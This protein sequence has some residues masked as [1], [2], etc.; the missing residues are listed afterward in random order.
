MNIVTQLC[1]W[2]AL[3]LLSQQ[4]GYKEVQTSL[5]QP[6]KMKMMEICD[7]GLD[8]DGDGRVDIFDPDCQC[9]G[10][11]PPNLVPNGQ[12]NQTNGCCADL[13]QVNCLSDWVVLGPSPDYISDNCPNTNLRPDVR[14]L[15]NALNQGFND[16]YIFSVVQMVD[17]RQFSES[18]G[19]CLTQ[20]MEAGKV[21]EVSFDLANLRNDSP[22]IQFSLVGINRCDRLGVY[23]TR[24]NNSFC[25]IGLPSTTLGTINSQDLVQGWNT[26]TFSVTPDE[27]IGAIFYTVECGFTTNVAQSTLYMVMDNVTIRET[28]GAPVAPNINVLGQACVEELGLVVPF[29][30]NFSYQWYKDSTL[31]AGATDTLLSLE[32][33]LLPY[34][35]VYHVLVSDQEGNCELSNPFTLV[36]PEQSSSINAT[37]CAGESY[38][39]KG[40]DLSAEGNY[41]DTLSSNW[42]CD[43]IVELQLE[44]LEASS[45][46]LSREICAGNPF[47]FGGRMLSTGGSYRDTLLNANG[48]DSIVLLELTVLEEQVTDLAIALC[49]GETYLFGGNILSA[50]GTY[51]DTLANRDGCDSVLVLELEVL[52]VQEVNIS[53]SI[54]AGASFP[55]AGNTLTASGE[56]QNVLSG[57]L[58]CD[59]TVT[60][61]L[62]V[63]PEQHLNLSATICDGGTFPFAGTTL[64]SSGIYR[65]TLLTAAGCDSILELDLEVLEVTNTFIS[66]EI[67]V[68]TTIDF[69]GN[70]ISTSGVYRDTVTSAEGCDSL[71]ILELIVSDEKQSILSAS[72][73]EGEDYLFGDDLLNQTGVY[74][75]TIQTM[76]GCD[77][78]IILDL[79]LLANTLGDTLMVR[80]PVGTSFSFAG[81]TYFSAGLYEAVLVGSNG[82]DSTAFLSLS[83]FDPC[84]VPIQIEGLAEGVSCNLA[85]NGQLEIIAL[86]DFPP[87]QYAINQADFQAN[88]IFENLVSGEYLIS[89]QDRFGCIQTASFNVPEKDEKL[90]VE[91]GKDTSIFLGESIQLEVL[92]M[93][94]QPSQSQWF[95]EE[96]LLCDDCIAWKVNPVVNSIYTFQAFD[97]FGCLARDE[98]R[99]EVISPPEFYIPNA[100]SPNNDGINDVFK[101]ESTADGLVSIKE[102]MIF[103]RWGDLVFDRKSEDA[104]GAPSWDGVVNGKVADLGVYVYIIKWEKPNGEMAQFAGDVLLIR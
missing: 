10:L 49:E 32:E 45:T 15:T 44:V 41:L 72:I 8:D 70:T 19:V 90:E 35:G 5:V 101:V 25:S 63:L 62:T 53:A 7:N 40:M 21:Y 12:F 100:F 23:D 80:Q 93:N 9:P 94:F 22:D 56:Y 57:A 60:L 84:E 68:G 27:E 39:F 42:G 17:N 65:D 46:L 79:T 83:F 69:G 55:F 59:S 74:R 98:I 67:C 1:C 91:L 47:D 82:C 97:E 4:A 3:A 13:G 58:G 77:S 75:D 31:I 11:Q 24:G 14:F 36:L 64:T 29:E 52:P 20:P 96:M 86:G 37:I 71:L 85:S 95:N 104:S 81:E 103:S 2:L 89:V 50:S 61:D 66:Q 102:M 28:I 87:F 76:V 16:G 33:A 26:L 48:C 30:P 34:E 43:S 73:C 51:R 6:G 78:I 88:S 54:C 18:M 99:V 92:G 38:M